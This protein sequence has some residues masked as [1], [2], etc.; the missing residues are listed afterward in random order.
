MQELDPR[1]RCDDGSIAEDSSLTYFN[2]VIAE[3]GEKYNRPI[4][5]YDEHLARCEKAGFVD[6]KQVLLKSPSN[7]W[8]KDKLLK[9]V[10]RFQLL[11]HLEG[12]EGVSMALLIRGLGWKPEEVKVLMAKCRTEIR[13]RSIHS[14]QITYVFL[15]NDLEDL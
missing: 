4:P 15:L 8:P 1:F 13:S 9:E 14:Y 10:G 11:A 6:V 3:A 2:K 7:P 5:L 12:L